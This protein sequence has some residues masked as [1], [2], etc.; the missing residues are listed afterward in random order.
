L[1]ESHRFRGQGKLQIRDQSLYAFDFSIFF[2]KSKNPKI[3]KSSRVLEVRSILFKSLTLMA[4]KV[5]S[6]SNDTFDFGVGFRMRMAA[7]PQSSRSEG[8][9]PIEQREPS[10]N[11]P[12]LA[13]AEAE[14]PR[15][16]PPK[17]EFKSIPLLRCDSSLCTIGSRWD[18]EDKNIYTGVFPP[19]ATLV[20]FK[21]KG[22]IEGYYNANLVDV[23]GKYFVISQGTKPDIEEDFWRMVYQ[24]QIEAILMLTDFSEMS[25][26]GPSIKCS[27]YFPFPG[28]SK[29]FGDVRVECLS[30]KDDGFMRTTILIVTI[31][32]QAPLQVT[33]LQVYVW[34]DFG[35][36]SGSASKNL[37][38][39]LDL[40]IYFNF[41]G[42]MLHCSAGL[43]RSGTFAALLRYYLTGESVR[44]IVEKIRKDRHGLVQ[45]EEQYNF[46]KTFIELYP[47][48]CE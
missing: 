5:L 11:T 42:V 17:S 38:H 40:F 20:S 44:D 8:S 1:S 4:T 24:L 16:E 3:D 15:P 32:S 29:N 39:L 25:L 12:T 9:S 22:G 26:R 47:R 33:H 2:G 35:I 18:N 19:D 7:A 30:T 31:G 6:R 45:T 37:K 28:H 27:R 46:I 48:D 43:G 13:P 34:Q 23:G 41:K 21:G 10:S 36:P 14:A